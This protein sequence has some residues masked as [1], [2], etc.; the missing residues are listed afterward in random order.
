MYVELM[1]AIIMFVRAMGDLTTLRRRMF[2][3]DLV[4]PFKSL[5]EED[6]NPPTA[7]WL[8]GEDVHAA[9][10]KAK[11]DASLADNL[12]KKGK[13]PK[14]SFYRNSGNYNKTPYDRK[15]PSFNNGQGAGPK[16]QNHQ[17][18]KSDNPRQQNGDN[19]QFAKQ[20]FYRR[21]SR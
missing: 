2:R 17:R 8:A 14:K 5:M 21:D 13:W 3:N 20:D 4:E 1:D 16:Q 9:M 7:D 19:R 15:K 11:S 6:K 18:R 10:R 12:T